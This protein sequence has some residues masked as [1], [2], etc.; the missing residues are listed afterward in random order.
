MAIDYQSLEAFSKQVLEADRSIRWAGVVSDNGIILSSSQRLG[1]SP[2]LTLEEN[3]EYVVTAISRHKTRTK[4]ESKIGRL[5]YAFGRYDGL[6]RATIPI[7]LHHY[8][9]ITLDKE[10]SNFDSMIVKKILPLIENNMHRFADSST[11]KDLEPEYESG[12]FRCARCAK[13]FLTKEEANSHH[14][15]EHKKESVHANE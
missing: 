13:E 9:L 5:R 6:N 11:N 2:L 1:L 7:N 3:E 14:N 12:T 8:L 15:Q 10:E 4:F